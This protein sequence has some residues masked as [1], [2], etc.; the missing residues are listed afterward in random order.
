MPITLFGLSDDLLGEI[1]YWADDDSILNFPRFTPH[2]LSSHSSIEAHT[3]GDLLSFRATCRRIRAICKIKPTKV[4]IGR[5]S[6][7]QNW[8]EHAPMAVVSPVRHMVIDCEADISPYINPDPFSGRDRSLSESVWRTFTKFLSRFISLEE[9]VLLNTPLCVHEHHPSDVGIMKI[10][11][12]GY[13]YLPSLRSL[14]I[15]V[16]CDTCSDHL[17]RLFVQASPRLRYLKMRSSDDWRT[18]LGVLSMLWQDRYSQNPFPLKMLYL[19]FD[20]T[21]DLSKE[22]RDIQSAWPLLEE[23]CT[24]HIEYSGPE[25]LGPP[26]QYVMSHKIG[27]GDSWSHIWTHK[28][29]GLDSMIEQNVVDWPPQ[30]DPTF[31]DV[32]N[33]FKL[34]KYLRKIDCGIIFRLYEEKDL[35]PVIMPTAPWTSQQQDTYL[36]Q[37]RLRAEASKSINFEDMLPEAMVHAAQILFDELPTLEEC[38]FWRAA[39]EYYT[40][41]DEYWCKFVFRR[42]TNDRGESAVVLDPYK[43]HLSKRSMGSQLGGITL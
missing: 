31:E 21:Y 32:L 6:Q 27:N 12:P 7:M 23:L 4:V 35:P 25:D 3:G 10:D 36:Q 15:E 43:H 24:N 28:T 9:L 16:N 34:F 14:A 13:E 2:H 11:P 39:P 1:A 30:D 18:T 42:E 17:P 37:I 5:F 33:S 22:L 38:V 19:P 26:N 40:Y 8:L 29:I 41:P 20:G